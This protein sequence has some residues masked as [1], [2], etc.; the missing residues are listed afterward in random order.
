MVIGGAVVQAN[1]IEIVLG[2][3]DP[4]TVRGQNPIR[5]AGME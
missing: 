3:R 5:F 2:A 4:G 1:V